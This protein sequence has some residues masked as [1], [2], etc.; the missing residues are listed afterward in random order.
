MDRRGFFK[1]VAGTIAGLFA[2]KVFGSEIQCD[3]FQLK[4]S[5]DILIHNEQVTVPFDKYRFSFLDILKPGGVYIIGAPVGF[6]KTLFLANLNRQV[7]GNKILSPS[8]DNTIAHVRKL[9][10]FQNSDNKTYIFRDLFETT[11]DA[12]IIRRI[13]PSI[14]LFDANCGYVDGKDKFYLP[15]KEYALRYNCSII[16]MI[17]TARKEYTEEEL[18]SKFRYGREIMEE[19][20]YVG[21]L[22][23]KNEEKHN[24]FTLKDRWVAGTK[25][26]YLP[27]FVEESL[28]QAV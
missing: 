27:K 7:S 10:S 19:A 22:R 9:F 3:G 23:D 5:S 8:K 6:G 17:Q 20:D 21:I 11:L 28:K 12:G 18:L 14:I 25:H 16:L 24:I 1:G 2:T 13:N 4:S 15:Y 26:Y